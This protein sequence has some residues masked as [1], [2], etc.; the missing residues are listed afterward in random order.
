MGRRSLR[1][2]LGKIELV[3]LAQEH[4]DQLADLR[5]ANRDDIRLSSAS[6]RAYDLTREDIVRALNH[7]I[8]ESAA[9]LHPF[10]IVRD[11]VIVGDLNLTQIVRGPEES[12]NVGLLVDRAARGSRVATTAIGLACRLAF[13]ELA[14][15]RL[16]AGV[17]PANVASQRAFV[18]NGFEQIGLARGY[19]FVDGQ[20]RDHLLFQ[21]LAP[22]V[23][24]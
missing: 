8:A 13:G 12:A 3:T 11:G 19:L 4:V 15:H 10:V 23:A 1:L 2:S 6:R 9:G 17:Q 14:L 20:W 7:R 16:Q 21:K 24:T 22:P 5:V 18:G